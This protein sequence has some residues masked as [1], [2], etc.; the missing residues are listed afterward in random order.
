MI[1]RESSLRQSSFIRPR[2]RVHAAVTA[3]P[4]LIRRLARPRARIRRPAPNPILSW[5]DRDP[6]AIRRPPARRAPRRPPPPAPPTHPSPFASFRASRASRASFR[7]S[8]R[9]SSSVFDRV[10][11]ASRLAHSSPT[12]RNGSN[13][14]TAPNC[15]RAAVDFCVARARATTRGRATLESVCAIIVSSRCAVVDARARRRASSRVYFAPRL[16]VETRS[17]PSRRRDRR[18]RARR[19]IVRCVIQDGVLCTR[20]AG[21]S[22][23]RFRAS[24][25]VRLAL[26]WI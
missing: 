16:V 8:P 10:P 11:F 4:I 17:S 24:R 2:A 15:A 22:F 26:Y 14:F 1:A 23:A 20:A 7:A 3:A 6:V 12:H 19:V 13:P 9:A 5:G 21:V 18:R 25:D